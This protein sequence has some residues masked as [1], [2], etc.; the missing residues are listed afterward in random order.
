MTKLLTQAQIPTIRAMVNATPNLF[1][2]LLKAYTLTDEAI[3]EF[4][5]ELTPEL[6]ST[7]Y[8]LPYPLALAHPELYSEDILS[9]YLAG[10]DLLKGI[11]DTCAKLAE[12]E[13]LTQEDLDEHRKEMELAADEKIEERWSQLSIS[14]FLHMRDRIPGDKMSRFNDILYGVCERSEVPEV[15]A[16]AVEL[17]GISEK[18]D[19]FVLKYISDEN[20]KAQIL[21]AQTANATDGATLSEAMLEHMPNELK[22]SYLHEDNLSGDM[23]IKV[24]TAARNDFGFIRKA[25]DEVSAGTISISRPSKIESKDFLFLIASLPEDLGIR[26]LAMAGSF[27]GSFTPDFF[28]KALIV[29]S[30]SE[31]QLISVVGALK[32]LGGYL[33]LRHCAKRHGYEKLMEAL[34]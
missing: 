24:L 30:F 21:L 10:E 19:K 25:M 29:K 4:R 18:L 9:S 5:T 34:N 12:D 33:A 14:M 20:L 13:T 22:L 1:P 6:F 26:L 11:E 3:E 31:E 23:F 16:N 32:P 28:E 7:S 27:P 2:S 8:R 17:I 15:E